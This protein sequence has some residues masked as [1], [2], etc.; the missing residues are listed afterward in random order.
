MTDGTASHAAIPADTIVAQSTPR[1]AGAIALVRVSGPRAHAIART[2]LSRFPD[3]PRELALARLTT[4]DGSA[5]Q[6]T[7]VRFDAP[8]SYTGED[9]VEIATHGGH[10]APALALAALVAA[11]ARPAEAGEFTRRAVLNGKLDLLQA[12]AVHEI[13]AA[14]SRA[15][16]RLALARLEGGLSRRILELR[17][18][19]LALEGLI[20]YDI[21]FPEEDDGPV[22]P[23]RI[24][25][26]ATT[27]EDA[28][29]R[30]IATAPVGELVREGV[31][32][33]LAGAPN[34]G[35]SSLFNALLGRER[36]IVTEI[37]GTTRDALE[38]VLDTR[39]APLRLVD[40]AGLRESDDRVEQLGVETSGRYIAGAAM[41]IV[42][43]D[44]VDEL[45]RVAGGV[46]DMTDAMLVLV[47]TKGDMDGEPDQTAAALA[48]LAT[49]LRVVA[50]VPVSTVSGEGLDL[51]AAALDRGATRALAGLAGGEADMDAPVI[52]SARQRHALERAREE[53]RAFVQAWRDD[54]L[55]A[56]IA[57]VHLRA[58]VGA[59]ES[60]I[61]RVDVE[62][63]LDE[64][65]SRFCVGK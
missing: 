26:A 20:A 28:L 42:C 32:T 27:L 3:S 31:L 47:R 36:A 25:A 22:A 33:V 51:L 15:E 23:A 58:A 40:T 37:P 41:V 7:V 4:E 14:R 43:A 29:A 62:D 64:V 13:I 6:V 61:G 16:Q 10:V 2:V 24:E 5:D 18:D 49:G 39:S 56:V 12:E 65:F 34:A 21:D 44:N 8:A 17:G 46:L 9:L 63:V 30:L 19:V 57:A 45:E 54:G 53:V 60:L 50:A 35:K 38:A 1:G 48:Q 55:P 59:L 52:A 11:G